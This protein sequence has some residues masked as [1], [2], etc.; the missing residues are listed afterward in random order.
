MDGKSNIPTLVYVAGYGRSGS[1]LI[2]SVLGN[3]PGVFGGGE[4]TCLFQQ[5]MENGT[6]S[7]GT[8][9]TTCAFWTQVF[10]RVF[11]AVPELDCEKA[12]ALTLRTE[13]LTGNRRDVAAYIRLWRATFEAISAVSG[14][15]VI[16]DSSKSC[17]LAQFRLP[18]LARRPGLP[19]RG[20]HLVRDPRGV[21]WSARRGSNR[22]LENGNASKQLLGGVLRALAGW[23]YSNAAVELFQRRR[24]RVRL[25]RMRYED[26]V[27]EP[28][29][30]FERLG[31][32]LG[33]ALDGLVRRVRNGM[34]LDPGHGVAGNR[35]RRSGPI[36]F[37]LDKEWERKLPRYARLLS[38]A[39]WPLMSK[40]HY[41]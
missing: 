40:Y 3:H 26:M 6:C 34:A 36:V 30:A 23:V 21:M 38:V 5:W 27:G 25:M 28:D 2:D 8:S 12:A 32:F 37:R 18:L 16:V 9:I 1:T 13:S 14:R 4:L 29:Q 17:R 24:P 41:T 31:G 20:I 19:V 15:R 7:C 39:A 35:M 33:I 10:D 22:R 11:Q